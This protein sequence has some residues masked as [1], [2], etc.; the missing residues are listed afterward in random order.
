MIS[1]N[2]LLLNERFLKVFKMLE[3]RGDIVLNDRDGKGMGDFADKILGNRAYGHIV[4]AFLNSDDKR[5]IDYHH[6]KELCRHYGVNENYMVNGSG[7]PFGFDL[8]TADSIVEGNN[9]KSNILFTSVKA[10]AGTTIGAEAAQED[11][12]FYGVP[13][14]SGGDLV[15]FPIDGNSM[16]PVIKNGDIVVCRKVD[17]PNDI[18]ENEIYAVKSN[19][20][21]WIKHVQP[22]FN[23]RRRVTKLRL[24]SANYLEHAP[25][26]ED[27]N[28]YTQL[29]KVIRKISS[30]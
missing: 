13:G 25:F 10:F 24:V 20:K 8:P 12:Q 22:I 9:V 15:S 18:K 21:L 3:E 11:N 30:L 23:L 7:S 27:V 4:R 17:S 14:I 1:D 6:I 19:G 26:E 5:V 28:E 2:R 16:E 29:Y